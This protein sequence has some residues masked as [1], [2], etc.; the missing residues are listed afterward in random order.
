[1]RVSRR[2]VLLSVVLWVTFPGWAID[3]PAPFTYQGYLEDNGAPA[4]GSFDL[5][6]APYDAEIDGASV[7]PVFYADDTAVADGIFCITMDFKSQMWTEYNPWVEIMVRPGIYPN[8]NHDVGTYT[9]LS[10]RQRFFPT[11]T[12]YISRWSSSLEGYSAAQLLD[13]SN[14]NAGTLDPA[15]YSAIDDLVVEGR[16]G[17]GANQVA[18]GNHDHTKA[19]VTD[20]EPI[21]ATPAAD[22]IPLADGAGIIDPGWLPFQNGDAVVRTFTCDDVYSIDAGDPVLLVEGE[23]H[24]AE[25]WVPFVETQ[26]LLV[27]TTRFGLGALGRGKAVIAYRDEAD[28][29]KGKARLISIENGVMSI[30]T[31][32][33]FSS[34]DIDQ[35]R[36]M[37]MLPTYAKGYYPHFIVAYTTTGNQ[38]LYVRGGQL[39]GSSTLSFGSSVQAHAGPITEYD[40]APM[41]T[42]RFVL[43][44]A[45][46]NDSDYGKILRCGFNYN[47]ETI[48]LYDVNTFNS[49]ATSKIGLGGFSYQSVAASFMDA[50]SSNKAVLLP[51]R[52]DLTYDETMST[53]LKMHLGFVADSLKP[54]PIDGDKMFLEMRP[55]GED[56][57]YLAGF[58]VNQAG[59]WPGDRWGYNSTDSAVAYLSPNKVVS[60]R[61]DSTQIRVGPTGMYE[62]HI[63]EGS[64]LYY[65]SVTPGGLDICVVDATHVI[66]A[67]SGTSVK[68][69]RGRYVPPI[70]IAVTDGAVG[71]PVDV[72]V[73]GIVSG[74]S[75]LTP[76]AIYYAEP[77]L[78]TLTITP[79]WA[80]IGR[81]LS[82]TELLLD[83][84]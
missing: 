5:A 56:A 6:F 42:A 45:D 76:G 69:S 52:W 41:I 80:R 28:G 72:A 1:M 7:G 82:E 71:Q 68:V 39:V 48:S 74:L 59:A 65:T 78:G 66:I 53:G 64:T 15:Y 83:I 73:S 43:A 70:G 13:A 32:L 8:T 79:G 9:I 36:V 30:G 10:P 51:I 24:P 50:G 25:F 21:S 3:P 34:S 62:N 46:P 14:I 63:L 23:I 77:R 47:M 58:C 44:Y 4:T 84:E 16:V 35:I 55:T 40:L 29:N 67:N 38:A 33:T 11:P 26:E 17:S 27:T 2:C 37:S 20:L 75:G 22:T 49:A 31:S 18:V 57:D 60:V 81:A 19:D 61:K 54:V 12:S